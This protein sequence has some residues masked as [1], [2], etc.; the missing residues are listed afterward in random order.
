VTA[1]AI[2]VPEHRASWY[3][4][5]LV[6]PEPRY[7]FP[8]SNR[9]A[10]GCGAL[11]LGVVRKAIEAL[12]AL[13]GATRPEVSRGKLSEDHGAQARLAQAEA[14]VCSAR[15]LPFDAVKQLWQ[16]VLADGEADATGCMRV[17]MA[18]NHAVNSAVQAVDLLYLSGGAT[19]LY[20]SFPLERAF[21]DVHAMTQHAVVH[22][23]VME[24]AG[25]V[26]FGLEPDAPIF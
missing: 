26:L 18:T 6:L 24:S 12:I 19:S 22:P 1:E 5:P 10:P 9:I 20:T 3:S 25:R 15:L 21:R 7:R 23:R 8:S 13:G 14:L 17:R 2:F 11:A 16:Q 4:D